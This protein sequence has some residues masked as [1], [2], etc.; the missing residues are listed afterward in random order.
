MA[1]SGLSTE[2][3][4][5]RPASGSARWCSTPVQT[6][7]S[8][9]R[10]NAPTSLDRQLPRLEVRQ[11]VFALQLLGVIQAG[12]AD[13]DAG[14]AGVGTAQRV[15]RGLPRSAPGDEDVQICAIRFVRPQ[16]MMLGVMAIRISPLIASAIEVFDGWGI[17]VVRVE[18]A[19]RIEAHIRCASVA[20][21]FE[22][23]K[24]ASNSSR[25][26]RSSALRR[27]R[28]PPTPSCSAF[29]SPSRAPGRC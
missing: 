20:C 16:Q 15:L 4:A 28:Q 3:S 8:K 6:I 26:R 23:V 17:G 19:H 29:P 13:V 7:R 1:P 10:S 24:R 25:P 12:R 18:L 27:C 5:R 9:R 22:R 2:R 11:V 21:H 14:D